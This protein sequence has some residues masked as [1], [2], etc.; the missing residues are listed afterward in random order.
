[1]RKERRQDQAEELSEGALDR[2]TG[3][4]RVV[5]KPDIQPRPR[6]GTEE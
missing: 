2:V 3:G 4:S 1:V 5:T 6:P